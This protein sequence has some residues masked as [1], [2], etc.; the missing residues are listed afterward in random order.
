MN[1]T[2]FRAHAKAAGFREPEVRSQPPGRFFETHAHDD[3]LII[4]VTEGSVTVDYGDEQ[5]AFGPGDMC[6]VKHGLTHRD[7]MGSEG[8]SYILAWRTP[9]PAETKA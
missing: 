7:A 1:E 3:D 9:L 6:E 5:E 4:L 2:E 8:A